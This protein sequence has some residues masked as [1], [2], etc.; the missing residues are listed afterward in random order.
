MK[1]LKSLYILSIFLIFSACN[2][3]KKENVK[4]NKSTENKIQKDT[5]TIAFGS[6][7]NQLLPNLFWDDIANDEPDVW[8]WG[9]DVIYSDTED[10]EYLQKNYDLQN[11]NP[12]YSNFIKQ[13]E[14]HGTWDDHD[15][16]MND[17][18]EHYEYKA[19]SQQLFLDF[20][21][22]SKESPRRQRE[23]IYF[24]KDYN[25]KNGSVKIILLD[26]RYF[27]SDLVKDTITSKRYLQ[28]P[29]G[30]MLGEAQWKWLEETLKKSTADF[31][32]IMSSIQ[33]LS[34]EH[35]YESWGT[36]PDEV[37]KMEDL[38][39]SAK[40][41]NVIFLSGDRHISEFSQKNIEGLDY[42]LIDFTS[43]GMTHSYSDF[44]GEENQYRIGNVVFDKSYGLLKLD[45]NKKIVD[46]QIKGD[47]NKILE[48]TSLQYGL[49][50]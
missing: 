48:T 38:L 3:S 15:Y 23:G 13:V 25:F 16:G 2:N 24:Q 14:I 20:L 11:A 18:G 22:V 39:V 27:R 10:M 32:I 31:N 28:A 19:E 8:L 50:N 35:G 40:S 43:S 30:T 1:I 6:C 49:N 46:F 21:G 33:F 34:Y 42:P 9:G 36:M 45:L 44:S 17:G 4:I 7:N 5:F 37:A 29:G 26:T 12:D 41:K 47:N